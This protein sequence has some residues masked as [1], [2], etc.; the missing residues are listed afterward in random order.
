MLKEFFSTLIKEHKK[1]GLTTSNA[2]KYIYKDETKVPTNLGVW[3]SM[4]QGAEKSKGKNTEIE[5]HRPVLYLN[6]T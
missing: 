1:G 4:K 6:L 3:H 2:Y 5:K